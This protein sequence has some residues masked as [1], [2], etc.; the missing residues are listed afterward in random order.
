MQLLSTKEKQLFEKVMVNHKRK[1]L[2]RLYKALQKEIKQQH[3]IAANQLYEAVYEEAYQK[4]KN[5]LLRNE[6]R[7][8]SNEIQQ[9]LIEQKVLKDI[10]KNANNYT[11]HFLKTLL[12]KKAYELFEAEAKKGLNHAVKITDYE[13]AQDIMKLYID[14]FML[15][16]EA[17]ATTYEELHELTKQQELF[18][19]KD[20]LYKFITI[21]QKRAFTE[22]TLQ[23][24]DPDK[25]VMPLE[26]IIIDWQSAEWQEAYLQYMQLVIQAYVVHGEEKI[27]ILKK[28]VAHLPKVKVAGFKNKQVM[29]AMNANIAL[30]YFLL[31]NYQAAITYH[32]QIF[33]LVKHIP[34]NQLLSYVFNY[35]S[36]L[37]RLEDYEAAVQLIEEYDTLL[38]SNPR[39]KDRFLCLKAM[40]YL[41]LGQ[42]EKA[43]NCI[44]TNTKASGL[45]NH[46]YFRLILIIGFYLRKDIDLALNEANNFLH[47][48]NYH[49]TKDESYKMLT[50]YLNRYLKLFDKKEVIGDYAARLSTLLVELSEN[51][52][53]KNQQHNTLLYKW[54]VKEIEK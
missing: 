39:L 53:L 9:F 5:Y 12:E 41:F 14:Y 22:R 47:S 32:Q 36:T 23:A 42:A 35:F 3:E 44:P 6:M 46:F 4:D 18:T 45:Q 34:K 17:R 19:T 15:H 1:T 54:L 38:Q 52:V 29:A 40:C 20:F 8:L 26:N 7:H 24:F 49:K 13:A 48:L 31:N 28:A 43:I 50:L 33:T 11:T 16:K 27:S 10:A 37:L 30:E 25:Q 51:E 2:I 21:R